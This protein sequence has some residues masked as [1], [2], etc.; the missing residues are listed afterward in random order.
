MAQF[1]TS[2]ILAGND[3]RSVIVEGRLLS[4]EVRTG[5]ELHIPMNGSFSMTVPVR[6]VCADGLVLVLDCEDNGEMEFVLALN[7]GDEVLEI[8]M[9][10]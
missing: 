2:K 4:G 5:M 8:A 9:P 6:E 3:G 7:F 1:H 10:C